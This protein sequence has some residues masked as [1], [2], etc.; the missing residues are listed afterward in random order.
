MTIPACTVGGR[1]RR[2]GSKKQFLRGFFRMLGTNE[3]AGVLCLLLPSSFF[4]PKQFGEEA[5]AGLLPCP[6]WRDP[7]SAMSNEPCASKSCGSGASC[8]IHAASQSSTPAWAAPR[9]LQPGCGFRC[10]SGT[11][12]GRN[13]DL[14]LI[15]AL[16][17]SSSHSLPTPIILPWMIDVPHPA[18]LQYIHC[19]AEDVVNSLLVIHIKAADFF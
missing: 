10:S 4:C 3:D 7:P 16:T 2:G 5:G 13:E 18:W 11:C 8:V 17:L 14:P 15:Q 1:A 6:G 9:P 12:S 19:H